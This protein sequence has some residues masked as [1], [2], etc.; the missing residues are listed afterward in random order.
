MFLRARASARARARATM[1]NIDVAFVDRNNETS[2]RW[3]HTQYFTSTIMST[4]NNIVSWAREPRRFHFHVL[5]GAACLAELQRVPLEQLVLRHVHHSVPL[6]AA[7]FTIHNVTDAAMSAVLSPLGRAYVS[8]FRRS[9]FAVKTSLYAVCKLFMMELLPSVEQVLILDSDLMVISDI[10]HLWAL[11]GRMTDNSRT[12]AMSY[13]AEQQNLYRQS[14]WHEAGNGY[15]GGV[16]VQHLGRLRQSATYRRMLERLVDSIG[17]STVERVLGPNATGWPVWELGDQT[18]WTAMMA[19]DPPLME[20]LMQPLPCEW[21]FQLCMWHFLSDGGGATLPKPKTK[22]AIAD[23]RHDGTCHRSPKILHGNCHPWKEFLRSLDLSQTRCAAVVNSIRLHQHIAQ[24]H[25][26]NCLAADSTV[27]GLSSR[28]CK[29]SFLMAN[30]LK[31]RQLHSHEPARGAAGSKPCCSSNV[32]SLGHNPQ[33]IC[34]ES[35][36]CC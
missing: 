33:A 1:A 13:A 30:T 27:R 31:L 19:I 4:A 7:A 29:A 16:G 25:R 3:S 36:G 6:T 21:N 5:A 22:S 9:T 26:R 12:V 2:S 24:F 35:L 18:V 11:F 28:Y 14:A 17:A 20:T 23:F 10:G 34:V 8:R 15:N 32:S